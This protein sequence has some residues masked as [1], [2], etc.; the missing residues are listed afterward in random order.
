MLGYLRSPAHAKAMKNFSKIG[1]G[2][3]YGYEADAI[4]SWEDTLLEW[5]KNGRIH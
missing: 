5:D 3:T 1:D 4:P 2:K